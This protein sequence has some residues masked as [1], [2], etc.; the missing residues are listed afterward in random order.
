M[1]PADSW[2]PQAPR[3]DPATGATVTYLRGTHEGGRHD[4]ALGPW[5]SATGRSRPALTLEV[6][7]DSASSAATRSRA[8]NEALAELG[9]GHP[10]PLVYLVGAL[11]LAGAE[12]LEVVTDAK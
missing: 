6:R 7:P 3:V 9:A 12:N 4:I 11:T 10:D 1:S 2:T 5:E 8:I